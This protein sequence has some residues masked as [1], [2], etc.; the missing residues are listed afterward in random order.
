METHAVVLLDYKSGAVKTEVSIGSRTGYP[1]SG[2]GRLNNPCGV[3]FAADG[4][5]ILVADCYNHRISKFKA[6]SGEFVAHVA[7]SSSNGIRFPRDVLQHGAISLIAAVSTKAHPTLFCVGAEGKTLRKIR[8]SSDHA[9]FSIS[10]DVD[11]AVKLDRGKAYLLRDVWS[12]SRR[13]AWLSA[14]CT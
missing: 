3:T 13:C 10:G 12:R 8:I 11:V 4:D 14:L 2:D 9:F 5:F 1:G 7:S 6:S